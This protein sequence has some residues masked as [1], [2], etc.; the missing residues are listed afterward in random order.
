MPTYKIKKN[1]NNPYALDY[2]VGCGL[3][4]P[5][6][7]RKNADFLKAVVGL[8]SNYNR[9]GD[10]KSVPN[11]GFNP[12]EN[13]SKSDGK[14]CG[15]AAYWFNQMK[16]GDDFEKCLL[17]A[18]IAIDRTN[19]TH[20]ESAINGRMKIKDAITNRCKNVR[21]LKKELIK[22]FRKDPKQHLIGLMSVE[23]DCKG[24]KKAGITRS[25]LSFASKFC[26]YASLYLKIKA[27]E[28]SKYDNVVASHLG[29]YIKL[30]LN[31]KKT[32]KYEYRY[33]SYLKNKSE[34][35]MGYIL[36]IYS[37]Y[38]DLIGKI[39][40]HLKQKGV[41]ISRDEFDRIVWYGFKGN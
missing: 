30:Y 22:D 15:S 31:D 20:L 23:M 1:R 17:G 29:D 6:L 32:H 11:K 4:I 10:V 33:D 12:F 21:D 5:A 27:F 25:N 16:K 2:A 19:S 39:I 13:P 14:Y 35:K 24:K 28:Y 36:G 26:T 18:I 38:Y 40:N 3:K 41:T 7:T 34:D 9:D 8:D 37:C